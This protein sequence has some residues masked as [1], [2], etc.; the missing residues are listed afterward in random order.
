MRRPRPAAAARGVELRF[1]CAG[2]GRRRAAMRWYALQTVGRRCHALTAT[3][4]PAPSA[5]AGHGYKPP[6]SAGRESSAGPLRRP[7]WTLRAELRI[8]GFRHDTPCL[9]ARAN[10]GCSEGRT[11]PRPRWAGGQFTFA[12]RRCSTRLRCQCAL[13]LWREAAVL[14]NGRS[15]RHR[16]RASV[17]SG[18]GGNYSVA[19]SPAPPGAVADVEPLGIPHLLPSGAAGVPDS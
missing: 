16:R 9:A 11:G 6:V 17:P 2:Q 4:R 18:T 10:D 14:H 12:S 5:L 19:G 13:A 3:H 15:S 7:G 8:H 1:R